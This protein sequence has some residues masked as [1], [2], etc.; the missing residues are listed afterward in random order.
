MPGASYQ[1][2]KESG[3]RR[4]YPENCES[5]AHSDKICVNVIVPYLRRA[6]MQQI[7]GAKHNSDY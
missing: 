6:I 1:D 2:S 3:E 7:F 4:T 5:F